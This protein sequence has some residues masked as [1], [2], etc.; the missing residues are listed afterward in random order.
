MLKEGCR[1]KT[2]STDNERSRTIEKRKNAPVVPSRNR[3]TGLRRIRTLSPSLIHSIPTLRQPPRVV[4][5]A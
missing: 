5:R 3:L 1:V 2:V 4:G